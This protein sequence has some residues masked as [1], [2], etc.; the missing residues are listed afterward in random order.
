MGG[1]IR[2]P[3]GE[4]GISGG[5]VVVSR[6]FPGWIEIPRFSGRLSQASFRVSLQTILCPMQSHLLE[7]Q[8]SAL[9]VVA[10]RCDAQTTANVRASNKV[11]RALITGNSRLF[12]IML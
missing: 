8:L 9:R 1:Y 6:E 7:I 4:G 12:L 3:L 5:A 2:N 10:R 11:L